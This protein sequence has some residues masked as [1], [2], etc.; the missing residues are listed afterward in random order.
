MSTVEDIERNQETSKKPFFTLKSSLI[1]LGSLAALVFVVFATYRYAWSSES[2]TQPNNLPNGNLNEHDH[3]QDQEDI[4]PSNQDNQDNLKPSGLLNGNQSEQNQDQDQEDLLPSNPDNLNQRLLRFQ[5]GRK[6]FELDPSNPELQSTLILEANHLLTSNFQ[7]SKDK[8]RVYYRDD[9][10]QI[11]MIDVET[12]EKSPLNL[13]DQPQIGKQFL[14]KKPDLEWV[15]YA[16]QFDN[17]PSSI[18]L[19]NLNQ[20]SQ[21]FDYPHKCKIVRPHISGQF[22]DGSKLLYQCT[23]SGREVFLKDLNKPNE[24]D[25]KLFDL[26]FS[27]HFFLSPDDSKAILYVPGY[28]SRAIVVDISNP[29]NTNKQN[30][31]LPRYMYNIEAISFSND[32]KKLYMVFYTSKRN[33]L[34]QLTTINF[35]DLLNNTY[36]NESLRFN[37]SETRDISCD[38]RSNETDRNRYLIE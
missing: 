33:P 6:I 12:K 14:L 7:V 13:P 1:L 2:S 23:E 38:V 25:V 15:V 16:T 21:K 36:E 19:L 30:V 5:F 4:L 34:F 17:Q 31:T 35:K 24:E 18:R 10:G 37:P 8:K 9:Y 27:Y 29:L 32:H 3:E 26:P 28:N 20:Q 22:S 11:N